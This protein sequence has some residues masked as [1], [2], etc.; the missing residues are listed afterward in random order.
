MIAAFVLGAMT[1]PRLCRSTGLSIR[2]CSCDAC[3]A[4]LLGAAPQ[5]PSDGPLWTV[6]AYA[7]QLGISRQELI[8]LADSLEIP[9]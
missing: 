5:P 7:A 1:A 2:G 6:E 9:E 4:R 8:E 3:R